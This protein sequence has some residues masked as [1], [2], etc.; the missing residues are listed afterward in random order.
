MKHKTTYNHNKSSVSTSKEGARARII[1]VYR[2][3]SGNNG[4]PGARQYWTLCN[5]QPKTHSEMSQLVDMGLITPDQFYGVDRSSTFIKKNRKVWP[6]AHWYAMDMRRAMGRTPDLNPAVVYYDS[7]SMM[8]NPTVWQE[9]LWVMS[10]CKAGTL[11]ALNTVLHGHYKTVSDHKKEYQKEVD[12]YPAWWYDCWKHVLFSTY[13][14][15]RALMCTDLFWCEAD[16]LKGLV[17]K[18]DKPKVTHPMKKL[19]CT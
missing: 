6:Q 2:Y 3:L 8:S 5:L 18:G 11:F 10:M 12:K 15:S 19:L 14:S 9:A 17:K 7:V 13:V 1:E 16:V 4:I